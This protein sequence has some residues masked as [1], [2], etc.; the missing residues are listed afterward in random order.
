[1]TEKT[2]IL[3]DHY[4]DSFEHLKGYLEKRTTYT[5]VCVVLIALNVFQMTNQSVVESIFN[6]LLH[7]NLDEKTNID[8]NIFNS[9]LLFV[10]MWALML[11]FQIVFL[12]EKNYK[13]I[14]KL[15]E[16]LE[17]TV[18]PLITRE[19]KNYL[20]PRPTMTK[21]VNQIYV[22]VFPLLVIV[23]FFKKLFVEYAQFDFQNNYFRFDALLILLI[24]GFSSLYLYDF[25]TIFD[26]N[27][28]NS[29]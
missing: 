8:F 24:I 6:A 28:S 19:G 16:E 27:Y 1:M 22:I 4:K 2:E 11:Y 17:A 29:F 13:Y 14:H 21:I 12:I 5:I 25:L 23:V 3:Y 20:S 7:K 18:S 9:L 15:E 10:T 26:L